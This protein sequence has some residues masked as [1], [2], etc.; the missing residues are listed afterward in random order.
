M[1]FF[2]KYS[3]PRQSERKLPSP[4]TKS[5]HSVANNYANPNSAKANIVWRAG[6][7]PLEVVG[8]SNYQREL[9]SICGRYTLAGND[10]EHSA[11]LKLEPLNPHDSNAIMVK[12]KGK[13]VGYLP[14]QQ[15]VRVGTQMRR[16]CLTEANCKARVRGG[17]R[18]NQYERGPL[19]R[20]AGSTN[21][22]PN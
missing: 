22:R 8:E 9:V 13:T 4:A 7:F 21:K 19:R 14:R 2:G 5:D 11:L 10:T 6:S 18:T 15:A 17:W 16:V 3:V 20:K 12:I 1:R